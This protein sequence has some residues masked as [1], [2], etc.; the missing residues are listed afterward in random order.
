MTRLRYCLA[1]LLAGAAFAVVPLAAHA[2]SKIKM[3]LNS[4][5]QSPQA[6]F[7]M[8][9]DKGC[10]K[11]EGLDMA[12]DQGKG[13][14]AAITKG[15]IATYLAGLGAI[16]AQIDSASERP[17]DASVAVCMI[18]NTPSFTIV[19]K[20]DSPIRAPKDLVAKVIGAPASDG[21]LT[22][23]PAFSMETQIEATKVNVTNM[24]PNLRERILLRG[25]VGATF[26]VTGAVYF[27]AKRVGIDLEKDLRFIPCADYA[28][29]LYSNATVFRRSFTKDNPKAATGTLTAVNRA[30]NDG[31]P[32]PEAAMNVVATRELILRRDVKKE[33]LIAILKQKMGHPEIAKIALGDGDPQRL[34]LATAVVVDANGLQ[35]TPPNDGVLTPSMS[36]FVDDRMTGWAQRKGAASSVVMA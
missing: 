11:A 30:V 29:D 12:I 8:A 6:W 24:V 4:R 5:D 18:D 1:T 35:R 36:A 15:A 17:A 3:T 13:W 32:S 22:L 19:V 21:A 33:R 31:L 7:F 16:N 9:Q 27:S 20:K 34:R 23:F 26:G 14:T 10:Y 28:M 2:Q 25:Q